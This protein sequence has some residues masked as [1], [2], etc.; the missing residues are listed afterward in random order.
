M[1]DIP[2]YGSSDFIGI[3]PLPCTTDC[4]GVCAVIIILL[5]IN[6][7]A[8]GRGCA[9]IFAITVSIVF[10]FF[11]VSEPFHFRTDKLVT[12]GAV[13]VY[14]ISFRLHRQ[15]RIMWTARDTVFV[16]GKVRIF[17]FRTLIE[18]NIGL[19]KVFVFAKGIT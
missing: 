13:C 8:T 15:R 1:V 14:R 16:D 12:E 10:T 2:F 9:W 5:D 6:H 4:T 19:A 17:E 7:S 18:R 3:L 11:F